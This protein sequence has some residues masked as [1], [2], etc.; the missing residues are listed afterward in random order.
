MFQNG[1]GVCDA[2]GNC[3]GLGG[4]ILGSGNAGFLSYFTASNSIANSSIFESSSKIGIL[5]TNPQEALD[6]FGA[7]KLSSNMG[8]TPRT[9]ALYND[10][11]NLY[12]NGQV[13]GV[14]GS[15]GPGGING[16]AGYL[17]F[18]NTSIL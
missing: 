3:A 5:T 11:G 8:T 9:N 17:P 7:I 2:S 10:G 4:T 12:W 14:T 15:T 13:V 6:V 18:F 1:Y 16:T